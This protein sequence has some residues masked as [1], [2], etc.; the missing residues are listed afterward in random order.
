MDENEI[1]TLAGYIFGAGKIIHEH[2]LQIQTGC[3]AQE[4]SKSG[5]GELSMNQ[6]QAVKAVNREGEAT[7]TRLAEI[8]GVSAPSAS[9]MVDRLVERGVL[10]RQRSQEDRRKV[11]V[12]VSPKAAKEIERVESAILKKFEDIVRKMGADNA[13]KWYEA[14][15]KVREVIEES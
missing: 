11:V 10:H 12:R 9:T 7:I 5:L 6:I 15:R 8:L 3:F 4:S 1:R 13:R 14:V 2:V